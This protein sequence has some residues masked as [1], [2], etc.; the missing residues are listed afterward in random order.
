MLGAG[1]L[2]FRGGEVSENS[3]HDDEREA[4]DAGSAQ[5]GGAKPAASPS[6]PRPWRLSRRCSA[7]PTPCTTCSFP[8]GRARR[9]SISI[10]ADDERRRGAAIARCF[11]LCGLIR[12]SSS[13]TLPRHSSRARFRAWHERLC[14]GVGH[15]SP[16]RGGTTGSAPKHRR[17]GDPRDQ[18]RGSICRENDG[19]DARK[20][21]ARGIARDPR[22]S[23]RT[24]GVTLAPSRHGGGRRAERR[25]RSGRRPRSLR[26][27]EVAT[28]RD[29]GQ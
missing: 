26:G 24:R 11:F 13:Q 23:P 14:A 22:R 3:V 7:A 21:R 27:L 19:A 5:R 28:H 9:E 2:C 12:S 4:C 8:G 16:V 20:D 6:P 10:S 29:P 25:G 18:G 17:G 1:Q 15:R